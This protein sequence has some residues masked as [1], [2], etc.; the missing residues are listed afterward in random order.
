MSIAS[1]IREMFVS[2]ASKTKLNILTLHSLI[3]IKLCTFLLK[4]FS[5]YYNSPIYL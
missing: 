1:L 3:L 4:L 5:Y 2:S